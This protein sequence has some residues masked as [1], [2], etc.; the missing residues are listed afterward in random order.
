MTS[1]QFEYLYAVVRQTQKN[2]DFPVFTREEVKAHL[3]DL[4]ALEAEVDDIHEFSMQYLT[5]FMKTVFAMQ[6]PE[7][8]NGDSDSTTSVESD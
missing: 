1:N 6:Q 4:G 8:P 3:S 2:I 7:S 5:V